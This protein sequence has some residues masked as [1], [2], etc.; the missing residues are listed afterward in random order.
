M[1]KKQAWKNKYGLVDVDLDFDLHLSVSDIDTATQ[2]V[3][4]VKNIVLDR[5]RTQFGFEKDLNDETK[6]IINIG[7]ARIKVNKCDFEEALKHYRLYDIG[8]SELKQEMKQEVC[9]ICQ[10]QQIWK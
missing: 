10:N 7:Y 5:V 4:G 3:D 6:V 9:E 1:T 2:I 8:I